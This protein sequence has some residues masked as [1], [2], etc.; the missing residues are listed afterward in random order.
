MAAKGP[1]TLV[2][3]RIVKLITDCGL[4]HF[5]YRSDKEPAIISTI[6]E[7]CAPAGCNGVHVKGNGEAEVALEAGD[8]A[9]GQLKE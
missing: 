3:N 8:S 9:T 2:M 7:A 5:A 1:D 6:Q 4:M